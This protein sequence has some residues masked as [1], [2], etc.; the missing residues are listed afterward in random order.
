MDKISHMIAENT[1][2][3]SDGTTTGHEILKPQTENAAEEMTIEKLTLVFVV[4]QPKHDFLVFPVSYLVYLYEVVRKLKKGQWHLSCSLK[5]LP[6]P[7]LN[8][9]K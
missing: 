8:S 3:V 4:N 5:Y 6:W 7:G 2:M 9:S 1:T